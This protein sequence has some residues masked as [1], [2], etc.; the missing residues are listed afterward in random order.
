LSQ[1]QPH[2]GVYSN[3]FL[4]HLPS[5]L[6]IIV[7]DITNLEIPDQMYLYYELTRF[8]NHLPPGQPLAIYW[9]NGPSTLLLQSFTSDRALLQAAVRKALP[10]FPPPDREYYTDFTTLHQIAVDL[11]QF[12]GR[13]NILWFSGGSTLFLN[14]NDS[15]FVYPDA[16]RNVYDELESGRIAIYPIDARGLITVFGFELSRLG[17]QHMLMSEIAEATG[18]SAF[19]DNNGLDIMT[20]HWLDTSGSFYTLTYSP[21]NLRFDNKWHKVQVKLGPEF[22]GYTLSYR[23]GYFADGN[24]SNAQ[25]SKKLRTL[26]LAGGET[27]TTPDPRSLPIIFQVR[28]LPASQAP[29]V[30]SGPKPAEPVRPRRGTTLY[31]IHYTVPADAFIKKSVD[32]KPQVRLGA[33][34]FEFNQDGSLVTRRADEFTIT[35]NADQLRLEPKE[36]IS[37]DQQVDLHKGQNYL[38]LSMWDMLS[39]RLGTLQIPLQVA[40]PKRPKS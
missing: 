6:N 30:S 35:L 23:R 39:G 9:C 8:L 4:L 2:P 36:L 14:R 34:F 33:A 29:P 19:Y 1:R 40:A 17:A 16:I 11:D 25:H 7:I 5:V 38:Y 26:L 20:G 13:K 22:R 12:P 31:S 32:G 37:V 15:S 24:T 27:I 18:G 10:H 21:S 3:D 28:V